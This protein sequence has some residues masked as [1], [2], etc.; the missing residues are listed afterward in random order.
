LAAIDDPAV[1]DELSAQVL[2]AITLEDI[3]LP[4]SKPSL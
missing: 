3:T 4:E 2:T 1:L